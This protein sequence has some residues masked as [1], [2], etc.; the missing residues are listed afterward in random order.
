MSA[1]PESRAAWRQLARLGTAAVDT[2]LRNQ[3]AAPAR[4]DAMSLRVGPLLLDFSRQRVDARILAALVVL[5]VAVIS[6]GAT[7][8]V[9]AATRTETVE[10]RVAAQRL[11][12]GLIEFAVQQREAD[13]SWSERQEPS[14][15]RMRA[16]GVQERW[17]VSTPV[18]I[19]VEVEVEASHAVG[20]LYVNPTQPTRQL[21][22]SEYLD[23]ICGGSVQIEGLEIGG[24]GVMITVVPTWQMFFDRYDQV[25]STLLAIVPPPD[26]SDWHEALTLVTSAYAQ[27]AMLQPQD[28][29][30][31]LNDLVIPQIAV[32]EAVMPTIMQLTTALQDELTA[33]GCG[34][35]DRQ[36]D[37]QAG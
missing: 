13:G 17:L 1:G 28:E 11:E 8:V 33:A 6:S 22:R 18:E 19:A 27:Y 26:L 12:G 32:L 5:V 35:G 25:T 2:H 29:L 31:G 30:V 14:A 23:L 36:D 21:S 9:L 3:V 37:D 10:V 24:E 15:N 20:D 7:L 34:L 4:F 16:E